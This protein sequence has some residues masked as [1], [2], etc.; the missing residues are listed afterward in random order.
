MCVDI[1]SH[2][3]KPYVSSMINMT[4]IDPFPLQLIEYGCG[5]ACRFDWLPPHK[6]PN[7]SQDRRTRAVT[8]L[9]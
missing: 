6:G 4:A 2:N 3:K 7:Y 1:T 8:N 9:R 5:S